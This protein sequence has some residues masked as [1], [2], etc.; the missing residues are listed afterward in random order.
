MQQPPICLRR[1]QRVP[2]ADNHHVCIGAV[3]FP[4]TMT[5]R[6]TNAPGVDHKKNEQAMTQKLPSPTSNS[7]YLLGRA[8]SYIAVATLLWCAMGASHAQ[9]SE[10]IVRAKPSVV[11]VGTF[12][13][14]DSPRFGLRGTG[15]VIG[16]GRTVVT[17]AHVLPDAPSSATV[18]RRLVV[19]LPGQ[20][21]DSGLRVAS[22]TAVDKSHDLAILKLD[23]PPLPTLPL[24][25]SGYV[26]EGT[27]VAFIGFPIGGVLGFSPV[28]HRGIVSSVTAIALP[29]P[30]AQNL[31]EQAVRRL[32]DGS[33]DIYQLDAVAYPGNSGGPLLNIDTGEVVGVIN[34]VLVKGSKET[35]L[36]HPTGISYAIPVKFVNDLL[37]R[38]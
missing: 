16:D 25:G 11:A 15:F 19:H 1:P 33:F 37:D 4:Q 5:I 34:M 29:A 9:L 17:N 32:R 20:S 13:P 10:L 28:T 30:S 7:R 8:R 6:M 22:I 14:T 35:A 23:G 24:A 3:L 27:G 26:S 12:G 36:S 38:R 2:K 21:G 18:L 31:N